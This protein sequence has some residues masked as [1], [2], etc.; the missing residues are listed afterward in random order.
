[1]DDTL[2]SQPEQTPAVSAQQDGQQ[3]VQRI[4][5]ATIRNFMPHAENQSDIDYSAYKLAQQA[6]G[7]PVL[8]ASSWQMVYRHQQ[9]LGR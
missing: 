2:F 4:T 1:M 3:P 5:A 9:L 7:L 8:P 6:L